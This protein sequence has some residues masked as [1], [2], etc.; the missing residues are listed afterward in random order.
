[1]VKDPRYW[2]KEMLDFIEFPDFRLDCIFTNLEGEFHR[3]HHVHQSHIK[4][5]STEQKGRIF[6]M[7]EKLSDLFRRSHVHDCTQFFNYTGITD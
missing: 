2:V 4:L 1:M 7:I 5:F 3:E 6:S